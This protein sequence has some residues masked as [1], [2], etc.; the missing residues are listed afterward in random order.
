MS[1]PLSWH[2]DDYPKLRIEYPW[3]KNAIEKLEQDVERL[4]TA[5]DKVTLAY[6]HS[7]LDSAGH[8]VEI[9]RLEQE[10]GNLMARINGDGGHKAA[11]FKTTREAGEHCEK[12][13][14]DLVAKVERLKVALVVRD[15]KND[16]LRADGI[17]AAVV[18]VERQLWIQPNNREILIAKIRATAHDKPEADANNADFRDGGYGKEQV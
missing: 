13:F 8:L 6:E 7:V 5:G 15:V 17:E 11:E 18:I 3:L 4:D 12:V 16:R 14:M 2:L 9:E 10:F 1:K